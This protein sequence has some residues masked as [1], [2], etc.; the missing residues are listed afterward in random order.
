MLLHPQ[1]A[2]FVYERRA[3]E[4]RRAVELDRLARQQGRSRLRTA[5]VQLGCR[6]PVLRSAPECALQ[7]TS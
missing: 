1:D 4:L 5:I 6:L 7:P 3:Y 2:I